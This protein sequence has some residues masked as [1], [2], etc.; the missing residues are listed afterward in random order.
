MDKPRIEWKLIWI[1]TLVLLIALYF[2]LNECIC[3]I[4]CITIL[5]QVTSHSK[6]FPV[7]FFLFY[8]LPIL[9]GKVTPSRQIEP[10]IHTVCVLLNYD[11]TH[12]IEHTSW[13]NKRL[14]IIALLV[15]QKRVSMLTTN[16]T[17]AFFS[18][19]SFSFEL[20]IRWKR[21]KARSNKWKRTDAASR[22]SFKDMRSFLFWLCTLSYAH[23]RRRGRRSS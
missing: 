23:R 8:S 17:P 5:R 9:I 10:H 16:I 19:F 20:L 1:I 12:N 3:F 14:A 18:C 6:Y 11:H 21:E 22:L 2:F 15:E 13:Y 4:D 7:V